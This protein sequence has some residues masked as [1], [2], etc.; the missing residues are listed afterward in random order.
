MARSF[1]CGHQPDSLSKPG[2]QAQLEVV[3]ADVVQHRVGACQ[4][5]VLEDAGAGVPGGALPGDELTL[6]RDHH[7]L[8]RLHISA[9]MVPVSSALSREN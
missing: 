6:R 5:D 8:A 2:P 7:H 9:H 1:L 3:D 4:V